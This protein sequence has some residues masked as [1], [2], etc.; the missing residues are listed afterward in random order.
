[1]IE[2]GRGQG[3]VFKKAGKGLLGDSL[4]HG[5]YLRLSKALLGKSDTM[6]M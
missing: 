2:Q 1:V 6:W 3:K 5:N 4:E